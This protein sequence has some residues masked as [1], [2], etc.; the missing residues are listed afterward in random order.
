MKDRN[1]VHC[2]MLYDTQME[3]MRGCLTPTRAKLE[4]K[5]VK[6]VPSR[7]GLLKEFFPFG[8][9]ELRRKLGEILTNRRVKLTAEQISRIKELERPYHEAEYVLGNKSGKFGNSG[10]SKEHAISVGRRI[11]GC[12][13]V[14]IK[15]DVGAAG[16]ITDVRLGG[17]FFETG[18]EAAEE[19]FRKAFTGL[20]PEASVLKD[21][22][23]RHHPER[24]IRGLP[25]RALED[26]FD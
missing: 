17:D 11:E 25:A 14:E 4:S 8:V 24:S 10:L 16:M 9:N 21:A 3:L 2:T 20:R 7:I 19:A 5:G 22:V 1:I 26:F 15:M 12:G 18:L 23:R 13:R 6:S